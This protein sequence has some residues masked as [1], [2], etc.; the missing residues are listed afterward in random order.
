VLISDLDYGKGRGYRRNRAVFM[1][2]RRGRAVEPRLLIVMF[3]GLESKALINMS[4]AE[5]VPGMENAPLS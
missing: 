5:Q 1:Q 2:M 3:V 4:R